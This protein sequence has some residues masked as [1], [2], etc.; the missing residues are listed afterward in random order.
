MML[1]CEVK[2]KREIAGRINL[3]TKSGEVLTWICIFLNRE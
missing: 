3:I 1:K 2:A